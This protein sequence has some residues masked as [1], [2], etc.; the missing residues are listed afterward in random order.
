M[1]L[2]FVWVF[3]KQESVRPP[4]GPVHWMRDKKGGRGR[5]PRISNACH[6]RPQN[7]GPDFK[8]KARLV[9][10]V[11]DCSLEHSVAAAPT[12]PGYANQLLCNG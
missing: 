12:D 3:S 7:G 5:M 2:L 11:A 6:S 10:Q 9:V 8:N 1:P 4:V